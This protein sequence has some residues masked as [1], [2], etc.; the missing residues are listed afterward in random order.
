MVDTAT[1][2]TVT[3]RDQSGGP[4]QISTRVIK[5]RIE[6]DTQI[7]FDS[8]GSE[9]QV[10]Y[11]IGTEEEIDNDELRLRDGGDPT[12]IKDYRPILQVRRARSKDGNRL[13]LVEFWS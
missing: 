13:K 1:I 4:A 2:A 8:D 9:K 10:E 5:C 11:K 7:L 3:A 12:K 6:N